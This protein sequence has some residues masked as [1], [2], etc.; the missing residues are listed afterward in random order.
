MEDDTEFAQV[1]L[2]F[3]RERNYKGII[4]YEGNTGL[5]YARHYRPDAIILD[6]K[7]PVM[8]GAD[9]LKQLKTDPDLRHIPVQIISGYDRKKEGLELGAFDFMQKPISTND[10][11]NA[12][13]KIEDFIS[14]KL[15]KLLIVRTL[16][17][18]AILKPSKLQ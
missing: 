18:D 8:D 11:Q 6:M 9:V 17:L 4:A 12:F 7:L 1:M 14:R 5:S 2:A 15:K 10:L 16:S 3:A 13:N